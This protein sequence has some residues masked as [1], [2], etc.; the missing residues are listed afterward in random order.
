[1]ASSFPSVVPLAEYMKKRD[2]FPSDERLAFSHPT[3]LC[4]LWTEII[5]FTFNQYCQGPR[6][7]VARWAPRWI[8]VPPRSRVN[9]KQRVF[10]WVPWD[11]GGKTLRRSQGHPTRSS[12]ARINNNW[13]TLRSTKPALMWNICEMRPNRRWTDL[14]KACFPL[15]T[16]SR[17]C[18]NS[19]ICMKHAYKALASTP[20]L[21]CEL[22]AF[23]ID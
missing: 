17:K 23:S 10:R 16:A 7:W 14:T 12:H 1:M 15:L 22:L 4:G 19:L 11:G 3:I 13:H 20:F 5:S 21:Y 6:G 8:D 18:Q 9:D 2:S